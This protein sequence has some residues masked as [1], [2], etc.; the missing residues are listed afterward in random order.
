M[1]YLA[2]GVI[3]VCIT[4]GRNGFGYGGDITYCSH[5]YCLIIL[6]VPLNAIWQATCEKTEDTQLARAY[7]NLSWPQPTG[8]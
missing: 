3:G 6:D 1:C 7:P 8:A 2:L 5:S 4:L